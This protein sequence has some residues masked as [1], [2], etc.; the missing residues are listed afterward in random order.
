MSN[1]VWSLKI[2]I[3]QKPVANLICGKHWNPLGAAGLGDVRFAK[4]N[5]LFSKFIKILATD[6]FCFF[7]NSSKFWPLMNPLFPKF[8]TK[9]SRQRV[10]SK[11]SCR[12]PRFVQT[13]ASALFSSSLVYQGDDQHWNHLKAAGLGF[14]DVLLFPK[15]FK[16]LATDES[17]Y[18]EI[19]HQI[20]MTTGPFK[21]QLPASSFCPN[22]GQFFPKFFTKL[23]R[24][25]VPSKSQHLSQMAIILVLIIKSIDFGISSLVFNV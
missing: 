14:F 15:S 16:I 21:K 3:H 20:E 25:R 22:F 1:S 12:R 18:S 10:P 9:L 5:L 17:A 11:S 23:S 19:L 8:F 2:T 4:K 6:E 24:W 13:V 7:R